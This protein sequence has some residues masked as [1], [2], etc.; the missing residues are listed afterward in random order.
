MKHK[1]I[2]KGDYGYRRQFRRDRILII[3][4][5]LVSILVQVAIRNLTSMNSFRLLFTVTAI[6]T[7]LPMGIMASPLIAS[8]RY[9]TPDRSFYD[10]IHPYEEKFT[11]LY[12]L[13]LTTKEQVIPLDAV[14]VHPIGVIGYCPDAKLDEK[15]AEAGLNELFASERLDPRIHIMKDLKNFERRLDNLKPASDYEDDG[16]VEAESEMFRRLCM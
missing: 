11:I 12:D 15:K 2:Q 10:D 8:W 9:R 16:V 3:I 13:I 4:L 7:V 1:R 5:L 6:L 14:V